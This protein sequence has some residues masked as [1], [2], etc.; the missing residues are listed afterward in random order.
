MQPY[1][2]RNPHDSGAVSEALAIESSKSLYQNIRQ[3]FFE[4]CN[5]AWNKLFG[6]FIHINASIDLDLNII[7]A[8]LIDEL[9]DVSTDVGIIEG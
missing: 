8:K 2:P 3:N 5:R 6:D 7:R 9:S 4:R 1:F